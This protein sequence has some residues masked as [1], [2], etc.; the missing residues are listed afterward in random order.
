MFSVSTQL[1]MAGLWSVGLRGQM[2]N[3]QNK[4]EFRVLACFFSNNWG[5][6]SLLPL[7]FIADAP[8]FASH[9][10]CLSP[11]NMAM[12]I[13]ASGDASLSFNTL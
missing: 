2:R 1:I 3:V 4:K 7:C 11:L 9:L 12:I 5:T 6:A 8:P 13:E 10:I